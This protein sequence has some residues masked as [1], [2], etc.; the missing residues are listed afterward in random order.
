VGPGSFTLLP[1]LTSL[2]LLTIT[3]PKNFRQAK[4]QAQMHADL[5]ASGKQFLADE[6]G[7]PWST[8]AGD[9]C[10]LVLACVWFFLV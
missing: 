10:G 9:L 3:I 2:L 1:F 4:A 5:Q 8:V 7:N 6:I